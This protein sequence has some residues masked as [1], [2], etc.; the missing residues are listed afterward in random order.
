VS[1]KFHGPAALLPEGK[2]PRHLDRRLVEL[3]NWCG[4]RG[5]ERSLASID[6]RL[7]R[8]QLNT[9]YYARYPQSVCIVVALLSEIQILIPNPIFFSY[10]ISFRFL[11][12]SAI[13]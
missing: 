3:Q 1:G 4:R 2:I 5:G 9:G 11:N 6:T 12:L 7:P 10:F 8:S 13:K